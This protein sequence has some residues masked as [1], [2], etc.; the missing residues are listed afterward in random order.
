MFMTRKYK[1]GEVMASEKVNDKLDTILGPGSQLEGD[2][3]AKGSLRIDGTFTGKLKVEGSLIVGKDGRLEGEFHTK[4]AVISGSVKGKLYVA[5]KAEF[6][7]GAKFD[8]E[9]SCKGLVVEEGVIFDGLCQ[10]TKK[11]GE[12]KLLGEPEEIIPSTQSQGK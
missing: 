2:L 4:N 10:M 5:E 12:R 8:G 7:S 3:S 11:L 6:Q 9:L 1:G